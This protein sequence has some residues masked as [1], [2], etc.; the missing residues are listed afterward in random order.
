MIYK[1]WN[2][3]YS[4]KYLGSIVSSDD[5]CEKDMCNRIA[6]TKQAFMSKKWL[7]TGKWDL[8]LKK[9]VTKCIVWSIA[10]FGAE[11]WTQADR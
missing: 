11:T 4:F 9:R 10:F 7:L 5:Y 8:Q 2:E 6:I 1:G 3:L